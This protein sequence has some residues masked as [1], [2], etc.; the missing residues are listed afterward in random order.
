MQTAFF[1]RVEEIAT[2]IKAP[3]DC[4]AFI[5]SVR[6]SIAAVRL[7]PSRSKLDALAQ[8]MTDT[9]LSRIIS[10]LFNEVSSEFFG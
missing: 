3:S 5:E 1:S 2:N 10:R 7:P 6:T 9:G 4:L 8:N